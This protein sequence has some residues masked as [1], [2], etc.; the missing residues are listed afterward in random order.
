MVFKISASRSIATL[1]SMKFCGVFCP[2]RRSRLPPRRPVG[3]VLCARRCCRGS[4]SGLRKGEAPQQDVLWRVLP[5][6][7]HGTGLRN[8]LRCC[9]P[10]P[11]SRWIDG[12]RSDA[13]TALMQTNVLLTTITCRRRT[14]SFRLLSGGSL[15][16]I[17]LNKPSVHMIYQLHP[18]F[19]T[20]A[21]AAG[22]ALD[23]YG[24]ITTNPLKAIK[25]EYLGLDSK[26]SGSIRPPYFVSSASVPLV[27]QVS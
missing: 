9:S 2:N 17:Y 10:G 1:I 8:S 21:R 12:A 7:R 16:K 5:S 26:I 3:I 23:D 25:P 6:V 18:T 20:A 27:N 19:R 4:G 11:G 24:R 22:D 14:L 15:K 13:A